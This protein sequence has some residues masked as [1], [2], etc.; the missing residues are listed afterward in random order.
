MTDRSEAGI[1]PMFTAL[2]ATLIVVCCIGAYVWINNKP[3]VH[4]GQVVSISTYPIHR[5]LST[6]SALGGIDGGTNVYDE[7]IVI[8]N[9]KIRSQTKLPLFLHDM[10]GDL[11]LEN[12]ETQRD[13]AASASDAQ[14]VFIAYPTLAPQQKAPLQ[15]DITLS[16]GQEVEGQLIFHYPISAQQWNQRKGFD[17]VIGFIHQKNLVLHTMAGGTAGGSAPATGSGE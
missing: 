10:Y 8:A 14:K 12:D 11:T 5:E 13:V 6:G 7:M 15:R 3:P 9:V 16:P 1:H 17:I 4:A 2:A